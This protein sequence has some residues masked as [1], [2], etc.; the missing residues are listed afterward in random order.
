MQKDAKA[1]VKVNSFSLCPQL[2]DVRSSVIMSFLA[3]LN[4]SGLF[5]DQKHIKS[6][7]HLRLSFT[8]LSEKKISVTKNKFKQ[9]KTHNKHESNMLTR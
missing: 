9:T 6:F 8:F 5:Y 1:L 2:V 3:P 7:E 4:P